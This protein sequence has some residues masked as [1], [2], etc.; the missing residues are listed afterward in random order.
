MNAIFWGSSYHCHGF[1]SHGRKQ[2]HLTLQDNDSV[3][4]I[5]CVAKAFRMCVAP[6]T[7]NLPNTILTENLKE[8]LARKTLGQNSE[9]EAR[10]GSHSQHIRPK[11]R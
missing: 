6:R 5:K 3:I 8:M 11:L 7:D 2:W 4:K 1:T 9:D 10:E